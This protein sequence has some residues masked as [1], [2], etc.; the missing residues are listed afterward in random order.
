ME[1]VEQFGRP[2][3]KS[4][5]RLKSF[6]V[7]LAGEMRYTS[8]LIRLSIQSQKLDHMVLVPAAII[9]LLQGQDQYPSLRRLW[10]RSYPELRV[11]SK[12]VEFH[13]KFRD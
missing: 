1:N 8:C 10:M 6:P 2:Q 11:E 13:W 9:T 4:G 5:I 7:H 12:M 3:G